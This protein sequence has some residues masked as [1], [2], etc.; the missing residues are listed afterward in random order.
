VKILKSVYGEEIEIERLH[1]ELKETVRA[2]RRE[3]GL[4]TKDGAAEIL[5]GLHS[6]GVP[7]ALASS[8]QISTVKRQ[9]TEAGFYGYFDVVIGGD[10]I[11]KS[12]P[13]PD[14]YLAACERLGVSPENAA[15][16]EDSFNGIRSAHAAGMTTIMVPDIVQ[17]DSVILGSVDFLCKNLSETL[18]LCI[19]ILLGL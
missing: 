15:A 17:P 18:E 16:V 3:H 13:A 12:K 11:E 8:T 7:L 14:I 9:L 2:M 5:E 19:K 6:R 4:P 1:E 10:M